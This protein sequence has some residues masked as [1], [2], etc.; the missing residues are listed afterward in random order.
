M[1]MA[2][3]A[4]R[5]PASASSGA[6]VEIAV[7]PGGAEGDQIVAMRDSE[8]P[9]TVLLFTRDEWRAFTSGVHAGEFDL[10]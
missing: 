6:G 1:D 3:A 5:R 8:N 7:L 10:A 9:A 4:W 2:G